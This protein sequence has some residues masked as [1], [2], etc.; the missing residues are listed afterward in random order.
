[1]TCRPP[2]RTES[3][4]RIYTREE[5]PT[6]G[7]GFCCEWFTAPRYGLRVR[8]VR[9]RVGDRGFGRWKRPRGCARSLL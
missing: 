1:M 4:S 9:A 2:E 5:D 7:E 8:R 3:F 6:M